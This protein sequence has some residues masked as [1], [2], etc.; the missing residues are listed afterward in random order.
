MKTPINAGLNSARLSDMQ[1]PLG[2]TERAMQSMVANRFST[3][4]TQLWD[5]G[6]GVAVTDE[7]AE[8]ELSG[9]DRCTFRR[10]GSDFVD[11]CEGAPND[12][13]QLFDS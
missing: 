6:R 9:G 8:L 3:T 5:R 12:F 1:T 4:D 2:C 13:I 11:I 7:L 10:Y